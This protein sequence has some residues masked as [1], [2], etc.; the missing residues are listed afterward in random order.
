M[1]SSDRIGRRMKLHEIHVLIA[2]VQ[3]GSMGKA[4]VLLNTTQSAISRSIADLENT[5]GVRL[6]DRSPLGTEAT[7]YGSALVKR[8]I[9]AFDELKQS[10]KDIEFL[11]DPTTG[12]INFACTPAIAFTFMPHVMDR[13]VKKYPRVVLRFD[14]VASGAA[15]RNYLELRNRKYDLILTRGNAG[16][17]KETLPD[18]VSVET[19][20]DDPLVIVAGARNKWVSRRRMIDLA[21]LANENWIMMPPHTWNYRQLAEAFDARGLVMPRAGIETLSVPVTT[22][23]LAEGQFIASM[24]KSTA[25]FNSLKVLPV[26][27]PSRPLPFNIVTLSNRTLSPV[28]ERFIECVRDVAK[29]ISGKRRGA[30][31]RGQKLNVS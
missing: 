28:V 21:E 20:F 23:F 15:T 30:S 25:Y 31:V 1:E 26:D 22:H 14:E 3:A 11:A 29:S 4:A 5:M 27:F 13:F 18:E 12:E 2:V 19:L 10:V 6:L 16:P 7:P 8:S 17:A 9:A 24:A